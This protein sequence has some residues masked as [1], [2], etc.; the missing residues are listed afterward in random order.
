MKHSAKLLASTL[1]IAIMLFPSA[2]FFFPVTAVEVEPF[3]SD[4]DPTGWYANKEGVLASDQYVKYPYLAKNLKIGFSKF[5][6]LI[7]ARTTANVGLE[8]DGAVDPF[9][10]PAGA[11]IGAVP[12]VDWQEG[13][14]IN[15]TYFNAGILARRNVWAFALHSDRIFTGGDWIRVDGTYDGAGGITEATESPDDAGRN[16]ST[17]FGAPTFG[18]E[19]SAFPTYGGR[20]TNGTAWTEDYKIVYDGPRRFVAMTVTHLFDWFPARPAPDNNIKLVDIVITFDFNKVKK[21]VTLLKD[22]KITIPSKELGDLIEN[23]TLQ[24]APSNWLYTGP[25]TVLGPVLDVQFSNRGEWDLGEPALHRSFAHFYT[26]GP[27]V[28]PIDTMTPAAG[29]EGLSTVYDQ[30]YVLAPTRKSGPHTRAGQYPQLAPGPATYDLAQILASTT[31]GTNGSY[32]GWLA[33]WPSTSDWSILSFGAGQ[34]VESLDWLDNHAVDGVSEPYI[35]FTIAEWDFLLSLTSGVTPGGTSE[36]YAP[37]FRAVTKYGVTDAHRTGLTDF[38]DL[39]HLIPVGNVSDYQ[40]DSVNRID[41]EVYYQSQENFNPWDLQDSV[42][43]QEARHVKYWTG[44]GET[45]TFTPTE[46]IGSRTD[47]TDTD[48]CYIWVPPTTTAGSISSSIEFCSDAVGSDT[49]PD[50]PGVQPYAGFSADKSYSKVVNPPRQPEG[51][52][53]IKLVS[54]ASGSQESSFEFNIATQEVSLRT[55]FEAGFSYRTDLAVQ[56]DPSPYLLPAA[57]LRLDTNWGTAGGVVDLVWDTSYTITLP[58]TGWNPLTLTQ[59]SQVWSNE[60]DTIEQAFA[61][62]LT[63]MAP[64]SAIDGDSQVL[65]VGFIVGGSGE[66]AGTVGY[67]DDPSFLGRTYNLEV[68]KLPPVAWDAYSV[69]P[70]RV[71]VTGVLKAR[72]LQVPP[73]VSGAADRDYSIDFA[74]GAITFHTAPATGAIIKYLYSTV[75]FEDDTPLGVYE[76]I[77]VGRDAASADSA[78]AALVSEA[79]DSLK[80]IQ[81]RMAGIDLQGINA[82]TGDS[83]IPYVMKRFGTGGTRSDYF[84]TPDTTSPGL[85]AFYRNDWSSTIPINSA[86]LISVGGTAVNLLTYYFND[87]LPIIWSNG[88]GNAAVASDLKFLM[89]ADWWDFRPVTGT[90]PTGPG[91]A[92]IATY[93][94]LD[95]TIG[96]IVYGY[97]A[98]DTYYAS[99]ALWTTAIKVYRATGSHGTGSLITTPLIEYLQGE[100]EGVTGLLLHIVYPSPGIYTTDSHPYIHIFERLGTI[101]E[102]PQH[103]P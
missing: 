75:E 77:V 51:G 36:L 9:A 5:G 6:E 81:V 58:Q 68:G 74:T 53:S 19:I 22:I 85:R 20:K 57:F 40:S 101:S 45:K 39:Q 47:E 38:Y 73:L 93:K 28:A 17:T 18:T 35:P 1:L 49:G 11:A 67:V 100:N 21:Y 99:A 92:V 79:F 54:N 87:F 25:A 65:I 23:R 10:P 70:E 24:A 86:N 61:N 4:T 31:A 33:A 94:D 43:K 91:Y 66:W 88:F 46:G 96:F 44:N 12:K 26:E 3:S 27:K 71:E 15:I 55:F 30:D 13:W 102:K 16:I 8:Y 32:V 89:P 37:Q 95:G 80:D 97:D 42:H 14:F 103:D 7:D 84:L 29:A 60:T 62:F 48:D 41:R 50:Y 64:N 76:W 72:D 56:T 78:G 2:T 90:A 69:F 63:G 59:T 98:Q 52:W 34:W 83:K 82:L